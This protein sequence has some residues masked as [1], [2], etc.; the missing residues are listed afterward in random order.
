MLSYP[1]TFESCSV[2][3]LLSLGNTLA[4]VA[5]NSVLAKVIHQILVNWKECSF[6][7][8]AGQFF[9]C[10]PFG[11]NYGQLQIIWRKCVWIQQGEM[12]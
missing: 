9:L 1:D 3:N 8:K 4:R 10:F 7:T 11:G 12:D 2:V 6:P 5:N